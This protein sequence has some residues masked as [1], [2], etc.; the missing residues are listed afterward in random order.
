ML[1]KLAVYSA[2]LIGAYVVVS[3]GTGAGQAMTGAS[4]AGVSFV[5]ALQG[6]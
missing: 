2:V 5:K 4:T 3:H 6:R 1:K